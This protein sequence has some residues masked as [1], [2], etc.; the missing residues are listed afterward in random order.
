MVLDTE[1]DLTIEATDE[2]QEAAIARLRNRLLGEHL[3]LSA[4]AVEDRLARD[5]SLISL[6]DSCAVHS[7]CLRELPEGSH[8][9]PI[10]SEELIDP[11]KP[12]TPAFVVR[13]I[14]AS[15]ARSKWSW[16]IAGIVVA[17][18]LRKLTAKR[19]RR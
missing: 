8:S 5:H 17:V 2:R 12:L 10:L 13:T 3:G 4:E 9:T 18:A 11:R 1:C 19:S 6:V 7:R 14:A 16:I 15:A